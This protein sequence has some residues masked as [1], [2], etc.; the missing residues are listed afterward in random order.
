MLSAL[1]F[2]RGHVR[3]EVGRDPTGRRTPRQAASVSWIPARSSGAGGFRALRR[4]AAIWRSVA[5]CPL[6]PR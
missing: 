1:R 2:S 3:Q 6:I 5:T 4:L